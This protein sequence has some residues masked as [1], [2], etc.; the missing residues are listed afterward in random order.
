MTKFFVLCFAV[1]ATVTMVRYVSQVDGTLYE[2]SAFFLKVSKQV[3]FG[4]KQAKYKARHL[5]NKRLPVK[6]GHAF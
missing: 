4:I 2:K 3:V 6:Y 5:F 1:A